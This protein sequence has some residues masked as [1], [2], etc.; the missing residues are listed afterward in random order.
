ML[1]IFV[2]KVCNADGGATVWEVIYNRIE[3]ERSEVTITKAKKD[4]IQPSAV[5]FRDVA[6]SF[7]HRIGARA[8]ILPYMDMIRW[9]V[10]NVNIE[11][12]QFKNS[13][14]ELMV[15]FKVDDLKQLYHLPNRKD[16][17]DKLFLANFVK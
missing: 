7:L 15:S 13:N 8:K 1:S 16:I 2:D 17:Y 3:D 11:Y 14:M 4:S 6:C 5:Q 9:V 12:R 10:E